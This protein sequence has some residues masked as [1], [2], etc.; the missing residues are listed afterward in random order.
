MLVWNT[1]IS[2]T[3]LGRDRQYRDATWARAGLVARARSHFAFSR[4]A[5]YT[6]PP[7]A[8]ARS[9]ARPAGRSPRREDSFQEPQRS[10]R[11]RNE[12]KREGLCWL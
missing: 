5:S 11:V 1:R 4:K 3:V 8:S 6:A 12:R 7:K 10:R 9:C 2:P